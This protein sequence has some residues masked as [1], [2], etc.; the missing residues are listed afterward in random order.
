MKI[1][2]KYTILFLSIALISSVVLIN[3]IPNL[4]RE[5]FN[6]DV[7]EDINDGITTTSIVENS[8]SSSIDVSDIEIYEDIDTVEIPEEQVD[9]ITEILKNNVYKNEITDFDAYLLIGSDERSEKIAQTRG[10]IQ[11]KRADVI[12]LGLVNKSSSEVS[13]ISFPR[14]LL[15]ENKCTNK[16]ER[17]N[18][19]YSRN[20]CGNRAE[21]LAAA[22][23]NISGI[24][25]NH[26][27]SFTFEGFEEIID[28][29][30]GVEI[31]VDQTQKEGYSFE[32]Q[33]GCQTVSGLTTLNWIVSR[34]TEVLVGEKIIDENGNDISEWKMMPGVSDLTRIERQ[35][36][37]VTQ[38]INELKSFESIVDLNSFVTA[39]ENTFVIDE[40]LSLNKAVEVL[41]TFRNINLSN[42]NKFTTPVDFITLD[43]GRQVL[44]LN[45]PLFDF[46][47]RNQILN[48]N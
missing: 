20:E 31:C 10:K 9:K 29:V 47:K 27:A 6:Q 40:N 46:L 16:I 42:V 24:K 7:I 12:I 32:L 13:L 21:N 15:I 25:V 39:L 5:E 14:D 19:T 36:Y 2:N 23:F 8:E 18:A 35:Q 1:L 4:E 44:V 3:L 38:L 45:E 30:E 17:I 26:F 48:S 11:G 28:S 43:D 22:I 37:V 41:W 34:S 33:K